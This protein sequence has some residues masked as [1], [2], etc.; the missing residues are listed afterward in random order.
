MEMVMEHRKDVS[1]RSWTDR[2]ERRRP[3]EAEFV[4]ELRAWVQYAIGEAEKRG[5]VARKNQL[6]S[7]LKEL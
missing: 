7:L 3:A 6:R 2:A 4:C 1:A 5:D